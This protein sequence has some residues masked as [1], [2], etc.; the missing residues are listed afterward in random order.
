MVRKQVFH[1]KNRRFKF[2]MGLA[3]SS[4][5]ILQS[6]LLVVYAS[7]NTSLTNYKLSDYEIWDK[8]GFRIQDGVITSYWFEDKNDLKVNVSIPNSKNV[9]TIGMPGFKNDYGHE[10]ETVSI[11]RNINLISYESFSGCDKLREV[12][13]VRNLPYEDKDFQYLVIEG[14]AFQGCS[15]LTS[16][17]LSDDL[18]VNRISEVGAGAFENCFSLKSVKFSNSM[19]KI[20]EDTFKNCTSLENIVIPDNIEEI[21]TGTFSGCTSLKSVT[22]SKNMTSIPDC[23]FENCTSLKQIEIPSNITN[24]S[25]TAFDGMKDF[26]IIC[27]KGSAAHEY[28]KEHDLKYYL[29]DLP[30]QNITIEVPLSDNTIV[31][32][33]DD[34][35]F[36]LNARTTGDGEIIYSS[37]NKEVAYVDKFGFVFISGV[38]RAK[39]K[40]TASCTDNYNEAEL[41][42]YIIIKDKNE[43][44]ENPPDVDWEQNENTNNNNESNN[45]NNVSADV[46]STQKADIKK[47]EVTY[48]DAPFKISAKSDSGSAVSYSSSDTRVFQ[49]DSNGLVTIKGYGSAQLMMMSSGFTKNIEIVVKPKENTITS[50]NTD[51]RSITVKWKK[52]KKADGYYIYYST[53]SKFRKNVK[54]VVISKKKTTKKKIKNLKTGKKYYFK[55]CSYKKSGDKIILGECSNVMKIKVK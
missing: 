9:H 53:N 13:F 37:D 2:F 41:S 24:I 4:F 23:A 54:E 14:Y 55:V 11:F 51:K 16:I 17:D 47:I 34:E 22:L 39:I 27:E 33:L 21:G 31:R 8:D 46:L 25:D 15:S 49:V 40:I 50:L 6:E 19:K 10:I 36:Y 12:K 42:F 20:S 32:Y 7:V 35:N 26:T 5:I 29:S 28:A 1:M 18:P 43:E 44:P 45:N 52:D 48:G 38:G 3:L 30:S